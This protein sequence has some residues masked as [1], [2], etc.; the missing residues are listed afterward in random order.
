MAGLPNSKRKFHIL[1]ERDEAGFYVGR[2]KE[3]PNAFTQARTLAQLKKRMAEVIELIMED[4]EEEY[5][6]NP[7]KIIEV[8]V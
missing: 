1:V 6:R 2:C 4:I 7:D 8:V 5:T 3:L